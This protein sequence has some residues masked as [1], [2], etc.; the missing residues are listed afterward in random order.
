M[1]LFI[2]FFRTKNHERI[3]DSEEAEN[4]MLLHFENEIENDLWP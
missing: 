3:Q 4:L 2:L 1:K